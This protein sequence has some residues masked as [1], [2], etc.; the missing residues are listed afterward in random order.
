MLVDGILTEDWIH[1]TIESL[2]VDVHILK[3]KEDVLVQTIQSSA[4]VRIAVQSNLLSEVQVGNVVE[5]LIQDCCTDEEVSVI[6]LITHTE[7]IQ[8]ADALSVLDVLIVTV[9]Q[10][11]AV[12]V[13]SCPHILAVQVNLVFINLHV[14]L[15]NQT[16]QLNER[17][18]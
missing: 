2:G 14:R 3:R 7:F 17:L 11:N 1:V 12:F 5:V 9:S 18:I 13:Y 6:R 8:V 4:N 15:S 16:A 10:N